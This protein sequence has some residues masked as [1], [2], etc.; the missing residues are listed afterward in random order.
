MFEYQPAGLTQKDIEAE[1]D[2]I[3]RGYGLVFLGKREITP[4]TVNLEVIKTILPR[5]E[6]LEV[7]N[8]ADD[9]QAFLSKT[10]IT[11]PFIILN[12]DQRQ[13]FLA[14]LKKRYG[15]W[16]VD[17]WNKRN[18]FRGNH[19]STIC[20]M[21]KAAGFDLIKHRYENTGRILREQ[22]DLIYEAYKGGLDCRYGLPSGGYVRSRGVNTRVEILDFIEDRV[23]DTLKELSIL[24]NSFK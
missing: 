2:R 20:M 14:F 24:T 13:E 3:Y 8:A 7:T 23:V 17:D 11:A 6:A 22:S 21:T 15:E 10:R 16:L 4:A 12:D 9:L 19:I 18:Q 5:R 1:A